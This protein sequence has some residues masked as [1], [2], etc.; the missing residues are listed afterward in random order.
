M[1]AEGTTLDGRGRAATTAGAGRGRRSGH[2]PGEA[3]VWVLVLGDMMVFGVLFVLFSQARAADPDVFG[4]SR[5]TLS[6]PFGL[7]NTVLLLGSSYFVAR[8]VRALRDRD[9]GGDGGGG[10][11]PALFFLAALVCGLGFA[12]NKGL[13]YGDKLAHGITPATNDFYLYYYVLTGIHAL[14]LT[15][16]MCVLVVLVRYTWNPARKP[17]TAVVEGCASY[18]HLVD[19]LWIVLFPLL[20][21]V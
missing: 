9:L 16:G 13:E 3:G 18:W 10:R 15:L 19:V 17:K 12:V 2:I 11:R 5:E 14:H 1:R 7:L 21:L 8:A 20:Y 6:L 4:A